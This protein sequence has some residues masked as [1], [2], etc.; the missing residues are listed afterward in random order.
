MAGTALQPHGKL[1]AAWGPFLDSGLGAGNGPCGTQAKPAGASSPSL[2]IHAHLA[3]G[4]MSLAPSAASPSPSPP[5]TGPHL[6]LH[7]A[8]ERLGV[9]ALAPLLHLS[10]GLCP[11]GPAHSQCA[12]G[13]S[14]LPH[15]H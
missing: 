9:S 8:V 15:P 3:A 7:T 12:Q 5:L 2:Y 11:P 10:L 13:P 14:S 4:C 6:L 1:A